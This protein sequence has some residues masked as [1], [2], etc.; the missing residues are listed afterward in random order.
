M[1]S[2]ENKNT[3]SLFQ[4][5]EEVGYEVMKLSNLLHDEFSQ[6]EFVVQNIWKALSFY[7]TDIINKAEMLKTLEG[8]V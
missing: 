7:S 6:D 8:A 3:S 5:L 2:L 1:S 4:R